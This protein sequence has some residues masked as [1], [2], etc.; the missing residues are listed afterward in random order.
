LGLEIEAF[1]AAIRGER[2]VAVSG[3]DG[4]LALESALRITRALQR[5]G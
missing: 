3:A 5:P 4:R 2:A 1:L